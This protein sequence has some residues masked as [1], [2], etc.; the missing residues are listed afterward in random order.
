MGLV[1]HG[2]AVIPHIAGGVIDP[3]GYHYAGEIG[4]FLRINQSLLLS[5]LIPLRHFLFGCHEAADISS[6]ITELTPYSACEQIKSI[7]HEDPPT[8]VM[9]Y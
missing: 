5:A 6:G 1:S 3:N 9:D 8:L 7:V 4:S 2:L